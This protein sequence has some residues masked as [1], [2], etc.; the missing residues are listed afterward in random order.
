MTILDRILGR[1]APPARKATLGGAWL[2]AIQGGPGLLEM[3]GHSWNERAAVYLAAYKV[4][5][6]YKAGSRI[7]ADFA[8]LDW[9]LSYEDSEG[10]NEEEI[11]AAPGNVPWERLAPLEQFLRLCERPNPWQTGL[12]FRHQQQIRL[13]FTGRAII[14]VED[15]DG[16]G[17][18]TAL[19]GIS[20]DRMWPSR[21]ARGELIG[22]LMDKDAP[23]GGVPFTAEEIIAV[24]T[25]GTGNDPQGVVEAVHQYAKL[26]PM[27][28]N[29]TAD[30]LSTGGRL[31][32]MAWPKER[33]LSEDEFADAQR[34]WRNVTSDPNAARRL[35][36]F[37]EPMEYQTGAATPEQI[38][39]P[40][41]SALSRDEV[42]TAFPISPE[43]LMVPMASGLNSGMTQ[44]VIEMRYWSGTMHP[45][46]EVWEETLQQALIPRYEQAVGRPLDF[47]IEEP[48]LDD[49]PAL[50]EKAGALKSLI[51]LGFDPKSAVS[52]VGLDHI[53]YL[54]PPE[55]EPLPV[56]GAAPEESTGLAV[57]VRDSTP[58]DQSTT[59]QSLGKSV[60]SREDV[61]GL[62]LPGFLPVVEQYLAEQR[63][64][65]VAR[66]EALYTPLQ[67]AE[68]KALPE[69]WWVPEDERVEL[70]RRLNDIYVTLSREALTVVADQLDRVVANKN[71]QR[72]TENVLRDAGDR[73]VEIS[74]TTRKA[75]TEALATGVE[76]GYSV[77]Q[78]LYGVPK[79]GYVGVNKLDVWEPWRAERIARTETAYAYN[80]A[81]LFGYKEFGVARVVASDG[82]GHECGIRDGQTYSV[83]EA[84]GIGDHP[85]GTLDWIPLTDKAWHR[86]SERAFDLATKAIEALS[87]VQPAPTFN[88]TVPEQAPRDDGAVLDLAAKMVEL[89]SRP[90][91]PQTFV[92]GTDAVVSA[93][94]P[95]NV[96]VDAVDLAPLI[97]AVKDVGDRIEAMEHVPPIV[98]VKAPVV[99]VDSVRVTSLPDRVHRVSRDNSGK[100]TGSVETDA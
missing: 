44:V 56:A 42:L 88:L 31:A 24:E 77:N 14:Y 97:E 79:E 7:A 66:I 5:W 93:L 94:Q 67:K 8:T 87:V 54:G 38:G 57:S 35:L 95:Q 100:P 20:P 9:T 10:D 92:L 85:N 45:R 28:P 36:L 23:S 29:H 55:P 15:A 22:W 82:P 52:A 1:N 75:V 4:D 19:Y 58:S 13:D 69:E 40:E 90:Q 81:A 51:D 25:P 30:V 83:E 65:V 21:N 61:V 26:A 37:P 16:S 11:T 89:A 78:M 98:N 86:E 49:A 64:R 80:E 27:I 12:A 17:L 73:I 62:I 59:S 96:Q 43:M 32:G 74:E 72:V 76:R 91:A 50:I 3:Y 33:S 41:L 47:D 60:K 53:E 2:S 70:Q 99:N 6:F 39:L 46:V 63:D 18:P 68:R 48:D 84:L 34:A 71:V